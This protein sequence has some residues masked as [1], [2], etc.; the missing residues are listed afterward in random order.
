MSLQDA[1]VDF[2]ML[3]IGLCRLDGNGSAAEQ[4][5]VLHLGLVRLRRRGGMVHG[6]TLGEL[7]TDANSNDRRRQVAI[8]EDVVCNVELELLSYGRGCSFSSRLG[9]PAKFNIPCSLS[10]EDPMLEVWLSEQSKLANSRTQRRGVCSRG[11]GPI[12]D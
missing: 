9:M 4:V 11:C 12:R 2:I 8:V 6:N 7:T 3:L 1:C 5:Q 10:Y